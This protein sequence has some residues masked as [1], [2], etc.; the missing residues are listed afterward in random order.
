[1]EV[2]GNTLTFVCDLTQNLAAANI[3]IW[4]FGGWAEELWEMYPPR[5]HHDIDLLYPA[6][7]FQ[8]LEQWIKTRPGVEYITGKHFYHKRAVKIQQVLIE[9][10]LLESD[11]D[12]YRTNFFKGRYQL[13]WPAHTLAHKHLDNGYKMPLAS[14]EALQLYR[15]QHAFISAAYRAYI[16]E[17]EEYLGYN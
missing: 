8:Y 12:G 17:S 6:S 14:I 11:S 7:D 16:E 13:R 2:T 3:Q 1:M 5:L 10:F 4:I 9:F 15:G